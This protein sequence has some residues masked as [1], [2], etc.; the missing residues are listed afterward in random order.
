[1]DV[2]FSVTPEA[3]RAGE[4]V[5]FSNLSSSGEEWEWTFGDGG[6]STSKSPTHVYRRAGTY[7]VSLK[8]DKKNSLVATR[9]LTVFDTIPTYVCKDSVFEIYRD[10]TF[11]ANVYNPY[12]Y[13]IGYAW[14][15][16]STDG[17]ETALYELK[18]PE[19]G[20]NEPTLDLYFVRPAEVELALWVVL[21]GDTTHVAKTFPVKDRATNSVVMRLPDSDYRQRI[22]G[23]QAEA[24]AEDETA[25][26]MLNAEQDTLQ[27][28]NG[29][30]FRLSELKTVF[31]QMEGF[32]IA[33]RK[34]Y[35]RA[36]GLWVA[37]I[38]GAYPVQIDASPCAA[39]TLDDVLDSR[40]Y[41]ANAQGV[42]YMPFVGS[43]NN[44]FVTTPVLLNSLTNITKIAVDSDLK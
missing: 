36:N 6:T 29:Y 19:K 35:Y 16:R 24:Y 10:Y 22:F 31:P 21:N 39:M 12:N 23:D 37:N 41:W 7:R 43:D 38:D 28:Y 3:P 30:E 44:K 18:N 2:N 15:V 26:D 17:M 1:V 42:W 5:R 20:L 4:S 13:A 9:E 34:I 25:A 32:H 40:I 8:V 14:E 33:N 11:T 27:F